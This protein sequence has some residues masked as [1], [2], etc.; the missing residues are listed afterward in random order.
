MA[1]V[2]QT[3]RVLT[4]A[5]L[6]LQGSGSLTGQPAEFRGWPL[7]WNGA[8]LRRAPLTRADRSCVSSFRGES[9]RFTEAGRSYLFRWTGRPTDTLASA[10][11]CYQWA[12][13]TVTADRAEPPDASWSCVVA[14]KSGERLRVCETIYSDSGKKWASVADW[15]TEAINDRLPGPYWAVIVSRQAR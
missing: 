14:A 1:L 7:E 11:A 9:A 4:A 10:R 12:G 2:P 8:K 5:A 15:L 6:I 3:A 13:Y